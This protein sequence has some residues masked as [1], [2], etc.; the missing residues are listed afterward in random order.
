MLEV[1]YQ[2]CLSCGLC[3]HDCY[4]K[5][6]ALQ[7]NK[8]QIAN[9]SA[10][11]KCAHCI[12]VCPT[13]AITIKDYNMQEAIDYSQ[14]TF[15]IDSD[16]L[17]NFIKTRRS[18]RH[19]LPKEVENNK[20]EQI[21]EAGRFTQTGGGNLQNVA[22]TVIS[23]NTKKQQLRIMVLKKLYQMYLDIPKD[24][25]D[26]H[27]LKYANTYNRIYQEYL[28]D[29]NCKDTLFFGAPSLIIVSSPALVHGT[30]AISNIILAAHALGLGSCFSGLTTR[31]AQDDAEI[32]DFLQINSKYLITNCLMIGYPNIK[33]LRTVPRNPPKI[34]WF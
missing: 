1:N 17:L 25:T 15:S 22:Y 3:V 19:Y 16:H 12:A 29:P 27:V 30:L 32:K 6:L 5:V 8:V 7:D 26:P 33:Y 14:D 11:V 18:V 28:A 31:A 34:T 9:Q 13:N 24:T 2:K 20:I 21:I 10:C 23:D 4:F